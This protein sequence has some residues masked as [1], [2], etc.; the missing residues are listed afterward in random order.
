MD[1]EIL[2]PQTLTQ[3]RGRGR[4]KVGEKINKLDEDNKKTTAKQEKKEK[5]TPAERQR[6]RKLTHNEDIKESA[7]VYYYKQNFG[8]ILTEEELFKYRKYIDKYTNLKL[9]MIELKKVDKSLLKDIYNELNKIFIEGANDFQADSDANN[10]VL[11]Q[12]STNGNITEDDI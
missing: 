9:A 12:S 6:L 1:I 10:D 2:N 7:K 11:S 5:L 8:N 4:P 3:K